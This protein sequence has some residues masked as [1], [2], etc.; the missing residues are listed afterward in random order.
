MT[1]QVVKR[2]WTPLPG[3]LPTAPQ[4]DKIYVLPTRFGAGEQEQEVP[5]YTDS[6]RYIPKE[7]RAAGIPVEFSLP[8][9]SRKYLSEYAI[10]PITLTIALAVLGPINDWIIWTVDL[11]RQR[12]ASA[13]GHSEDQAAITPLRVSLAQVNPTS[14]AVESIE[15]EGPSSAVIEAL[16]EMKNRD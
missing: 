11:F 12:R 1:N 8:E 6:V 5:M 15:L 3:S 13:A 7:G 10:D 14:G 16:K 9:G 4:I 2:E